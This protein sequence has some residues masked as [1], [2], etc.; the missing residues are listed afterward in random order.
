MSIGRPTKYKS[1]FPQQLVDWFEEKVKAKELPFLSKWA[2]TQAGVSEQTALTWTEKDEDFLE[3]YKKAK[4][5]QKE[6]LIT[7]ALHGKF[8]ATFA[9]FTA[10]NITDMRDKN[11]TVLTN[12]DGNL[13][14]IIINKYA[15][16]HQSAPEADG[17]LGSV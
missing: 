7:Q 4:D 16:S 13:K 11:E 10:K 14:T 15:G 6:F 9:I 5:I 12:P 2:R 17:G 8:N 1:S 3:A